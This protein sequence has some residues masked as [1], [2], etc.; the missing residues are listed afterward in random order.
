MSL[1]GVR[2]LRE[3][4]S[5]VIR[6]V[7]EEHAEYVITYQGRPVAIILPLDTDRAEAEMVQAGKKAIHRN[8]ERYE[9]I[10]NEI[11][12]AWPANLSTQDLLDDIRR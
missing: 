10:A 7:R 4:A 2:E 5:E 9:K 11:R 3:R 8:G 1:I 12:A 6:Q